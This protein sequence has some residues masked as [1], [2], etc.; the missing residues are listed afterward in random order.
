MLLLERT[1]ITIQ[2]QSINKE[3]VAF[4][5][6]KKLV[7]NISEPTKSSHIRLW[8]VKSGQWLASRRS[9]GISLV[10][11]HNCVLVD[12][13]STLWEQRLLFLILTKNCRICLR[14]GASTEVLSIA[15]VFTSVAFGIDASY[16]QGAVWLQAVRP[17][18][19]YLTI[20]G[21][22]ESAGTRSSYRVAFQSSCSVLE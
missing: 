14:R 3:L 10:L 15:F 8:V 2:K 6:E 22:P 12:F 16:H 4:D 21:P 1:G 5:E 11:K 19:E 7:R 17:A 20:L 13:V 18:R 9:R